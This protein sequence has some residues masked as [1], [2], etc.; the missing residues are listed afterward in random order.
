MNHLRT[1]QVTVISILA[2]V[3]FVLM[4][5]PQF[6]LIPGATFLKFDF[7]IVPAVLALYWM[8]FGAAL[9][10]LILRTVLKLI[11][12]NE[13]VNTYLGLPINLA[14]A[15]TFIGLLAL[16]LPHFERQGQWAAKGLALVV[17][18][19]GITVVAI[20]VNL[21]IA[22]PLYQEFAHFDIKKILGLGPYLW[23]MVLPFNLL[24]GI[25]WNFA[26]G[27]V[28]ALLL[29]FRKNFKS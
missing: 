15:L 25:L 9:W 23:G 10:V 24:Q 5:V 7:S 26:S 3:S 2:A 1:R 18:T 14:V 20:L 16:V 19:V 8:N 17:T 4:I 27:L 28:V 13:G 21:W 29:P 22:I 6:S 12:F 11:L